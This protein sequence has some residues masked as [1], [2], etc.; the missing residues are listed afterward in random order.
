MDFV[1]QV[2]SSWDTA[3]QVVRSVVCPPS[4]L[5]RLVRLSWNGTNTMKDFIN[6]FTV[7]C[8]DQSSIIRAAELIEPNVQDLELAISVLGFRSASAI[9]AI[10]FIT[11]ELITRTS[12]ERVWMPITR[13]L[14]NSIEIGY[15]FGVSAPALGPESGLLIGF[16]QALGACL[17]LSVGVKEMREIRLFL[18]DGVTTNEFLSKFE[19][20][21]CQVASL[22]LQKLGFG[23]DL[24]S[25]AVMA[26]GNLNYAD[27]SQDPVV[28]DWRAA[29]DWINSLTHGR[30]MPARYESAKR[31]AEL[32]PP[33][34]PGAT[35]PLHLQILYSQVDAIRE[36][37]STWTWHLPM[38]SYQETAELLNN[39]K[40]S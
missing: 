13:H 35:T 34:D 32:T 7:S 25:A 6:S 19:C 30:R 28:K 33:D 37:H 36:M 8:V 2:D 23:L 12:S 10:R 5:S 40:S 14:M 22:T 26:V 38:N 9:A 20:E 39:S 29:S 27:A 31:F 1:H 24:S 16:A 15:H 18:R 21:P 17:L 11:Q 4:A 3:V